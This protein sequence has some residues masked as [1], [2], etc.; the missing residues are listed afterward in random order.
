MSADLIREEL[1]LEMSETKNYMLHIQETEPDFRLR[2]YGIQKSGFKETAEDT[3][4]GA[5]QEW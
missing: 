2:H 1:D 5:M 4:S 3:K